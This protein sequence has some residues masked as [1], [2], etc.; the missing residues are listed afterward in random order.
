MGTSVD[1]ATAAFAVSNIVVD[2]YVPF[3][4]EGVELGLVHWLREE[5]VAHGGVA[6]GIWRAEPGTSACDFDYHFTANETFHV[7]EGSVHIKLDGGQTVDVGPGD[8]ATFR[9]GTVSHWTVEAPFKKFFVI[10]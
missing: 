10:S 6:T 2:E 1:T 7:I 8:I 9:K 5:D 4:E 3:L